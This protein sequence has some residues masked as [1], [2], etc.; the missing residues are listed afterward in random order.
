MRRR[1]ALLVA[2][3][4][5]AG[6]G[7]C[8]SQGMPP[9]G[10]PDAELPVL[11]RILPDSN[12]VRVRVPAVVLQF[13]EVVSER[14][15]PTAAPGGAAAGGAAGG[16]AGLLVLS[17]SDGRDE[18]VWRREALELRPRG[19]FRPN[20]AYRV[21]LL[22]G[23]ADLRGNR[24]TEPF[25]FVFSTGAAIPTGEVSGVLFDWT[26]GRPAA[27]ARVDLFRQADTLFRW[28][29]RTD[30]LGRFRVRE[31]TSGLYEVRAWVDANNDRRI[32]FREISDVARVALSDTA[33]LELYAYGRD[34]LPPR[35]EQVEWIDS[36]AI[37]IRLDRGIVAD[38]DGRSAELVGA[39]SAVI[40]LGGPFVPS[41]VYDSLARMRSAARDST[42]RDS[43]AR[44]ADSTAA[45]ADSAP[46][47]GE[48]A[49]PAPRPPDTVR[50]ENTRPE[51][52]DT[53]T[54]DSVAADSVAADSIVRPV[55]KRVV[56]VTQWTAPL[57]APLAPGLYRFRIRDARGL[58]GRSVNTERE[59]RVQPPPP[60]RPSP[61]RDRAPADSTARDT[62]ARGAPP[63][64]P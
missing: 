23:L 22:P 1:L 26:T 15:A 42:A 2:A 17:P 48:I 61:A 14:S 41:A 7:G 25:S 52:R 54:R 4:V 47:R 58:N 64:R 29:A 59:L 19:G 62:T 31:L 55:F 18:V 5:A 13:D 43:V 37:R 9:G 50:V 10:P 3:T 27:N 60:P 45:A 40:P 11:Q 56:P 8:A 34:T 21:T 44:A 16:L 33:T 51:P 38:W 12:A 28:S 39:D 36:T 53:V 63:R 35:L 24:I 20:T 30:S 32:S 49:V 6:I 57:A 46:T